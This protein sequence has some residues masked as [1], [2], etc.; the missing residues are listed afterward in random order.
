MRIAL[1]PLDE[2]PVNVDLPQQ[3]AA[4][5]GVEIVVPPIEILPAMRKPAQLNKLHEWMREQVRNPQTTHLVAC[6]DTVVHGGIIPARITSDTT[7]EVLRRLA[8]FTELRNLN[9]HMNVAAASLIM[10]ASDSYSAVEEPE[11][12]SSVGRQL[13]RIG[14]DLH[15]AL[16]QDV[17]TGHSSFFVDKDVDSDVTRDFEL[18]RLRNHMV[19]LATVALHENGE[20]D[21][22]ALT[23]DDTA[24]YS[25]GSA[26]QVWLR[27]WCRA[28]PG[29]RSVMMYP[30]A[31]EV[32]AVLVARALTSGM[33]PPTFSIA[34]GEIDG[35]ERV[36]NFENAPLLDSLTRQ[37]IAAGG[38]LAEN[39][40]RPDIVLIAHAPDP[41]HGDYF[42][43][44]PTSDPNAT[45][46]T[47]A[48]TRGALQDGLSVALA[49]VRFSNGGDPALVEKLADEGLLM[50][51][52]SYGGWNT[53]GNTIGGVVAQA[54][55]H[56]VGGQTGTFDELEAQR[57]LLTRVLDD[58]AYQSGIRPALHDTIFGGQIGPVP[59]QTQRLARDRIVSGLQ[60][61]VDRITTSST[62]WSVADVS[63]PWARSFEI[64]LTLLPR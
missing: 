15:R 38:R 16:E 62:Q 9:P 2:R 25:A 61:Y 18:R 51:L 20:L 54:I 31:D 8:I 33:K 59:E 37:I 26:E 45:E 7:D 42:G 57:A 29:G 6:I 11:Y 60:Q 53:A 55:A 27:H 34:C 32:G 56:W 40:E 58:S 41:S 36:P 21:T 30:G 23:A 10:R 28:L 24:P 48:L 5:A 39:G 63:L 64:G 14:G 13:H 3:V 47:I 43:S 44:R 50:K 19:N 35:L 17:Q 1:V 22:L 52:A 12:W 46:R 49:D 4:I